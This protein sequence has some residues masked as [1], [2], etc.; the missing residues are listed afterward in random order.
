MADLL[1]SLQAMTWNT[2]QLLG[3]KS[4]SLDMQAAK[5]DTTNDDDA[6][7]ESSLPGD[8]SG[9]ASFTG[10]YDPAHATG[11]GIDDLE[12]DFL[13][14]TVAVLQFGGTTAG[15]VITTASAYISA[16]KRNGNHG[17]AVTAD[18]TW[19]LTGQISKSAVV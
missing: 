19:T 9:T 15:D 4:A 14:K 13:A 18:V 2:K 3:K 8:I 16:F 12:A 10:V 7:F 1:G 11:Q 5:V 17:E 6:G